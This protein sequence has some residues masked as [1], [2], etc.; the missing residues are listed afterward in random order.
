M[1]KT[2]TIAS[3]L[4]AYIIIGCT[5]VEKT[6]E[7]KVLQ[8]N[9]WHQ[10]TTVPNGFSGLVSIID[11]TDPDIV[12][13]SESGGGNKDFITQLIDT[14]KTKGKTYYGQF[15]DVS[16]G[17]ISK[18][19][20]ERQ[21]AVPDTDGNGPI[22]KAYV[23]VEGNT[24]AVYSAHLDYLHY[25]CYMP[26]GYS[27][28][29]W[30]KLDAPVLDAAVVLEANRISQRDEAISAFVEEAKTEIGKGNLVL[31]GGDFNEP[32]H[33]DWQADTKDLRDHNG[34]VIDWDCS[35]MLQGMGMLD[36]YR[37]IYPDPVKNP[38]FTFPSANESVD[39]SKLTWAPEA[40]ERDRIDF[41]YYYPNAAWKLSKASIVGP[42]ETIANGKL[43]EKDSQDSF[44]APTGIWPTDHKAN[45]ATFTIKVKGDK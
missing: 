29:T 21:E 9:I 40:D 31:I 26:R 28:T 42:E 14:L 20:I 41:I 19:E 2:I 8:I 18:Y 34:V 15:T 27:G 25:E 33:L 6:K 23:N 30:K 35:V 12:L 36:T 17:L 11:Q 7:L 13:L 3:L 38:G 1:K 43:K 24:L 10:T 5:P 45:L 32:S 16:A 4:F 44:I 37:E 39:I 22:I